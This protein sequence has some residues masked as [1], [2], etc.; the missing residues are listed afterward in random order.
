M[1][2][3]TNPMGE[4]FQRLGQR[5]VRTESTWWHEVQP[6]VFLSFPY[7][8]LIQPAEGEIRALF[9]EHRLRAIRYTTPLE[10]FGFFSTI[11]INDDTSYD[12]SRIRKTEVRRAIR[13]GLR[14]FTVQ[15]IDADLLFEQGLALN[16]DTADRQGRKTIYTD[17]DYWRRYCQAVNDTPAVT[18]WG[19]IREGQLASY[20]ITVQFD[21]WSNWLLAHS[22]NSMLRLRPTNAVYYVACK[23]LLVDPGGY[24]ICHGL[25]S[26]EEVPE[27]DRFKRGM[28]IKLVP[29]KQRLAFSGAIRAAMA[30][31]PEPVL[32]VASR[33]FPRSYTVRKTAAMFRLYHRQSIELPP[34]DE[35]APPEEPQSP[36]EQDNE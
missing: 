26:L 24:K 7:Y 14:N 34:A 23:H 20:M 21:G 12:I 29:I 33:L 28:G 25:G 18:T 27:L 8:R 35:Q 3:D 17:P 9:R 2:L 5:V 31:A 32:K 22:L 36:G 30:L 6:H 16:K 19:A 1:T 15:L 4:F 11:E 10:G 13:H